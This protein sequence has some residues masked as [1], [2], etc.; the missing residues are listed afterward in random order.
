MK[1]KRRPDWPT[2]LHALVTA[3]MRAPFAWGQHDCVLWAADC[4]QA[5]TGIDLAAAHRGQYSTALGAMRIVPEGGLG[6]LVGQYLPPL[7]VRRAVTGDI[8]LVRIGGQDSLAVVNGGAAVGP[9]EHGLE[10]VDLRAAV[11]AWKVG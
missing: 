6:E 2:H 8:M 11:A 1:L 7:D 3:R 9:A 10:S 5:I 4:V